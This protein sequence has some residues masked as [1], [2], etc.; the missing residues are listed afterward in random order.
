[1][2]EIE[3]L[4]HA[5]GPVAKDYNDTQLRQ[6]SRELDLMAEFLLDLSALRRSG[7]LRVETADF[8]TSAAEPVT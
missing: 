4:K 1:M 3:E 8:D 2:D 5:L 7:Q 6:L